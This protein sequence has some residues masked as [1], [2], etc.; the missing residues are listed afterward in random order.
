MAN[1]DE[2]TSEALR[3]DVKARAELA[4]R[5]LESLDALTEAEIEALWV[6]EAERRLGE[7]RAGRLE[8]FSADE[9]H[10]E[11]QRRLR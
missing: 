4:E 6:A 8:S 9:V 1:L 7:Y 11:A 10:Q 3:L 2:L 5:L